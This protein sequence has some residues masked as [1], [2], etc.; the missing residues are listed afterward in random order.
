[1]CY[2]PEDLIADI[3]Q[4]LVNNNNKDEKD[5][6]KNANLPG[7]LNQAL[8]IGLSKEPVTLGLGKNDESMNEVSGSVNPGDSNVSEF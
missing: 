8:Q 3:M 1:M 6:E 5:K 7:S 2:D 4:N